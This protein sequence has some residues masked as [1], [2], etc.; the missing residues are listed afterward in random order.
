M[1]F[2]TSEYS[3]KG[4]FWLEESPR[5]QKQAEFGQKRDQFRWAGI[6]LG[7]S[8]KNVRLGYLKLTPCIRIGGMKDN[9]VSDTFR[10]F[11]GQKWHLSHQNTQLKAYFGYRSEPGRKN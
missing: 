4:L 8:Q 11:F 9:F 2:G 5:T 6:D 10:H 7:V 3:I 1:A